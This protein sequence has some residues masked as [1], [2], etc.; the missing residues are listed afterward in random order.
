MHDLLTVE[1]GELLFASSGAGF[2]PQIIGG[3]GTEMCGSY[4]VQE[5]LGRGSFGKVFKG[6]HRHTQQ[7]V[8]LKYINKSTLGTIRDVERVVSEIQCL[9]SLVHPNVIA[10]REVVTTNKG[11]VV[12]VM[13]FAGG[14][15]LLQKV[16]AAGRLDETVAANLFAQILDGVSYCH[17]CARALRVSRCLRV[18]V[19]PCLCVSVSLRLC[20]SVSLC[21]F[22]AVSLCVCAC[23]RMC[24]C[25]ACRWCLD[26]RALVT[27]A[28][29]TLC[30]RT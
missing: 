3:A 4:R 21:R 6:V 18:S 9:E 12:L 24:D 1:D 13:E 25:T 17:R 2:T 16:R 27:A 7:V 5:C 15:D 10:L 29:T 28:G 8:A 26:D 23:V 20:V 11:S 22:V 30:I 14:G 19:S